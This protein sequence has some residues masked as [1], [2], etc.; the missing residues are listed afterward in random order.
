MITYEQALESIV[1]NTRKLGPER[2]LVEKSVGRILNE[3]IYSKI[4]MPPFDKSAMD[5]YA[6]RA[7]DI[8]SIP[9][10]LKC[11]GLIQAGESFKRKLRKGECVKIMTGARLPEG[12]DAVIMIEDTKEEADAIGI[13]KQVKKKDNVCFKGEDI[14][15]GQRVLDK[16]V[17]ITPSQAAMLATVGR[18]FVEV[19]R[20]PR[21]S[22][23]NTGGEIVPPG[24]RLGRNKIY[25]SNGPL[26]CSFLESD[27][28]TARFLGIVKDE[29]S[30][31]RKAIRK[32][33]C[34]DMLLISG[35]VSMG[36]Y[37]LI[38]SVLRELGVRE[39]F[40]KVNVKPGRP[41]FFG[42]KGKALVFGIPGNP[43]SNFLAYLLFIRPAAYKMTGYG[44]DT[45]LRQEGLLK[46]Q[47]RS[48]PGRR[49]FVLVK[50]SRK[51]NRYYLSAVKSNGS[52]DTLS[53]SKADGFMMVDEDL[54]VIKKN[55]KAQFITWKTI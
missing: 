52:A 28:I 34:A 33:L 1:R 55:S 13:F 21:V 22:L 5:G 43:V 45:T 38:P 3:D 12:A 46:E 10:G 2:I 17:R 32:G 50:I 23:I 37:D 20:R 44:N 42:A 25:N 26:L 29:A 4:A 7:V 16:G 9:A 15:I 19:I 47:F 14:K 35:G 11:V 39:I 8:K 27:G 24:F 51:K 6:V 40:H 48:K 31:L 30:E 49:H 41:L 53:L 54:G 36:D 18:S